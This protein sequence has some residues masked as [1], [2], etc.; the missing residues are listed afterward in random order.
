VGEN[1]TWPAES[2]ARRSSPVETSSQCIRRCVKSCALMQVVVDASSVAAAIGCYVYADE[3]M[4]R[5]VVYVWAGTAV[6]G[7]PFFSIR[8]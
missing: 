8:H 5:V 4:R 6:L 1:D 7:R 2:R 3:K